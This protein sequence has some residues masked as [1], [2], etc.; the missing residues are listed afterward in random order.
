MAAKATKPQS[1]K[2]K[3][4]TPKPSDAPQEGK[5]KGGRPSSSYDAK[6]A[7]RVC[8]LIAEGKAVRK[9]CGTDGIPSWPTIRRWLIENDEFR[10]QYARAREEQADGF[11]DEIITLSIRVT[12]PS[13]AMDADGTPL[14]ELTP[15]Q[16]R[17]AIDARKWMAGKLRPKV[18]GDT[19]RLELDPSDGFQTMMQGLLQRIDGTTRGL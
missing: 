13:K 3:G 2:P 8:E 19:G 5:N 16:A 7:D 18:Y 15:D 6:I 10:T 1:V 11:A 4:G 14:P 17:V 12:D 9:I